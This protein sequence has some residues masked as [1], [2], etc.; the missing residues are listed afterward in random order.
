MSWRPGVHGQDF[1]GDLHAMQEELLER[2]SRNAP[3]AS[4]TT[5][6]SPLPLKI[7]QIPSHRGHKALEGGSSDELDVANGL[8]SVTTTSY[9]QA[10][11]SKRKTGCNEPS[12]KAVTSFP[13]SASLCTS[14]ETVL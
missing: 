13:R 4:S 1:V 9:L 12:R 2:P 10:Q 11:G 14:P 7:P 5:S 8:E 3:K 6:T